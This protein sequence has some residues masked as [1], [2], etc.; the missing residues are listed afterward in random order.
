MIFVLLNIYLHH[1]YTAK[2]YKNY[3]IDI[4]KIFIN[5]LSLPTII[6]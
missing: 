3:K 1:T 6:P 4:T 5:T 2:Y